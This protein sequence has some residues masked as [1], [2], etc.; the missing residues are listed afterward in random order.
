MD[1]QIKMKNNYKVPCLM[2]IIFLCASSC[3]ILTT[4]E[5]RFKNDVKP[6]ELLIDSSVLPKGYSVDPPSEFGYSEEYFSQEGAF[7][8]SDIEVN[9]RRYIITHYV[10][11]YEDITY[12]KWAF[13][14][15][16]PDYEDN[17]DEGWSYESKLADEQVMQCISTETVPQACTYYTR[18]GGYFSFLRAW[19]WIDSGPLTMQDLERIAIEIDDIMKEKLIISNGE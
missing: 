7:I 6:I 3:R 4:E 5:I 15:L 13:E 12:A 8:G 10:F 19:V 1:P 16:I 17:N 9:E 18:Y 2:I 14:N 11:W